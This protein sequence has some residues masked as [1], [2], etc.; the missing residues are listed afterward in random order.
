MLEL[1]LN[2]NPVPKSTDG[3]VLSL[4]ARIRSDDPSSLSSSISRHRTRICSKNSS[5][6]TRPCLSHHHHRDLSFRSFYLCQSSRTSK[7]S[8]ILLQTAHG[9]VS[10]PPRELFFSKVGSSPSHEAS[11]LGPKT[12]IAPMSPRPLSISMASPY[13]GAY[14]HC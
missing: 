3:Y 9:P 13:F 1:L 4:F 6:F 2:P 7:S 10:I 5:E 12:S 14:S 11:R 8:Y